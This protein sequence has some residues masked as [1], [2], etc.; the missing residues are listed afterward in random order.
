VCDSSAWRPHTR[1]KSLSGSHGKLAIPPKSPPRRWPAAEACLVPLA[2]P[3][4]C[5][6]GAREGTRR[7]TGVSCAAPKRSEVSA[8]QR[9]GIQQQPR[10]L[11]R[12]NSE[13]KAR[14][15]GRLRVCS[16]H[17]RRAF[18]K[19]HN[20]YCRSASHN[21]TVLFFMRVKA[22]QDCRGFVLQSHAAE[23]KQ[24]LDDGVCKSSC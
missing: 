19:S 23:S 8:T 17:L 5:A 9:V 21:T 1:Q 2:D 24:I 15:S 6:R 14:T 13:T 10:T 12:R 18:Q 22:A 7:L 16:A 20:I 3:S 11:S 4:I